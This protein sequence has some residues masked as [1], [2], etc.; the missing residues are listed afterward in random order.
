[1]YIVLVS[2]LFLYTIRNMIE[3]RRKNVDVEMGRDDF[4]F[5]Y[6]IYTNYIGGRC[7]QGKN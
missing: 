1:M 5:K 6:E 2:Y 3:E 7:K 4:V